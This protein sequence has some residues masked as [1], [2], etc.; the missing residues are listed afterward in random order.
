MNIHIIHLAQT[1]PYLFDLSLS[2]KLYGFDSVTIVANSFNF[3][4]FQQLK[5]LAEPYDF[6]KIMDIPTR[7]MLSHGQALN[8]AFE[9]SNDDFFCFADHDIFPTRNIE[10]LIRSNLKLYDVICFG[11]RPENISIEY[12][13]LSASATSTNSD[14]PIASSFFSIYKR[15]AISLAKSNY[16][17]GF[18]Q[19]FRHSQIPYKLINHP[20]IRNLNEPFLIDTNKALSLAL[21]QLGK[22]VTSFE[23][24]DVCHLGGLTGAVTRFHSGDMLLLN[25]FKI[26][27]MPE[28]DFLI[29]HYKNKNR[30]HPKILEV[31]R[32]ISDFA[33]HC[34]MSLKQ[35]K[36][37]PVFICSNS[38]L[39]ESVQ[40][41]KDSL[42]KLYTKDLIY[43]N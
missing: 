38:Q 20:D 19:Y 26:E 12:K 41:I 11:D 32:T 34:I 29:K 13:G 22:T 15:S 18:E 33:L 40:S 30:R 24:D 35:N 14:I 6:I 3:D 2:F 25:E 17:V 8:Y 10:Q 9:N 16:N 27:Y 21:H 28:S 4:Q 37:L 31:K 43:F 39:A 1:F 7:R 5:K 42:I 36:E 23:T